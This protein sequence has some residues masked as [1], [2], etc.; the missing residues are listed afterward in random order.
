MRIPYAIAD[1]RTLEGIRSL[2]PDTPRLERADATCDDDRARIESGTGHRA[3]VKAPV[4]AAGELRYLLPEVKLRVEGLDLLHEPV[5][6][7]LRAADRQRRD[8]VDG[9]VGIELGALPAGMS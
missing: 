9:L 5:D 7:L 6:Q 3:H 1:G 2:E 4:V 8:V